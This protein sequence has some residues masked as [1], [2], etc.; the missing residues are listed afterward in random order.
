MNLANTSE[1]LEKTTFLSRELQSKLNFSEEREKELNASNHVLE[2]SLEDICSKLIK[3]SC[4]YQ[5][6]EESTIKVKNELRSALI[7]ANKHADTA[8][9]KY[10]TTKQENK[11]LRK[12]LDQTS[13]EL[14]QIKAHRADLQR[15]R[16]HAPI[17]YI[18]QLHKE[19]SLK[20]KRQQ[21]RLEGADRAR[22]SGKENV[23]LDG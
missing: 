11:E 18:N 6:K 21:K 16:K 19:S 23:C 4:I 15:Q 20:D 10:E 3:L 14:Q 13:R 5:S 7:A 12:K 9:S 22:R 8:I 1:E 17:S 2:A